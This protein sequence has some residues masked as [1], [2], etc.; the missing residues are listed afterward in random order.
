M[1]TTRMGGRGVAGR[2]GLLAALALLGAVTVAP[3]AAEAQTS[4]AEARR[5]QA[6][7]RTLRKSDTRA[8]RR[9][10]PPRVQ[11][12]ERAPVIRRGPVSPRG[13]ARDRADRDRDRDGWNG[14]DRRR[15]RDRYDRDRWN[16]DH[17]RDR[18]NRDRDRYDRDRWDHDRR[19]RDR[20]RWD[21]DRWDRDR[22][23]D[24]WDRYRRPVRRPVT[25][26]HGPRIGL[27]I[28]VLPRGRRT[29]RVR[30]HDYWYD[31]GA[32]Y[33]RYGRGYRVIAA[34][35][36]AVV[37]VLPAFHDVVWFRGER[38]FYYDGV[39]FRANRHGPGYVVIPT[40]YGVEVPYLPDGY[41][42]VWR[43]GRR[44]YHSYGVHY[45]PVHR[46][47]ITFYLSVRL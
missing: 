38:L 23:R 36:G 29:I 6:A 26:R 28:N 37:L 21:G 17:E 40:P 47:G 25:R 41:R 27:T 13:G 39:F 35:I 5:G 8:E 33:G 30:G 4:R 20:D 10:A 32:F 3:P 24:R 45:R 16:R 31:D 2:V 34:P 1:S 12:I 15:N 44:Y 11:R 22:D 42:E 14:D 7:G 43:G 9:A 46:S 19:D 18:W